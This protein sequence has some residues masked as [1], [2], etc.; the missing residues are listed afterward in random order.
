MTLVDNNNI[1]AWK[2]S[3]DKRLRTRDL[4]WR[5]R[6]R[7]EMPTL[8]NAN[9][10]Y[11]LPLE[12][13]D[14]LL[15]KG[16]SRNNENRVALFAERAKNNLG[17]DAGF[18]GACRQLQNWTSVSRSKGF[19]QQIDR[20]FMIQPKH[21]RFGGD[22]GNRGAVMAALRLNPGVRPQAEL[23]SRG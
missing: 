11:S 2:I 10:P 14:S 17:C 22:G 1:D 18:P 15:Y 5:I 9:V 21:A 8:Q 19:A 6:V 4:H 13:R 3:P 16:Q 7:P 20:G 12:R 23:C